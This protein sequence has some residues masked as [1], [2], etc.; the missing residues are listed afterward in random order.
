[1][2]PD[3]MAND[4]KRGWNCRVF[5]GATPYKNPT[6]LTNHL[7]HSKPPQRF[8]HF[9]S[10]DIDDEIADRLLRDADGETYQYEN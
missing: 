3:T 7:P 8:T 1:M 9:S 2:V 4:R 10:A 6:I 5:V